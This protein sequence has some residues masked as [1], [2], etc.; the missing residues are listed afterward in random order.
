MFNYY[1]NQIHLPS[2]SILLSFLYLAAQDQES[3]KQSKGKNINFLVVQCITSYKPMIAIR[4]DMCDKTISL[5]FQG[6]QVTQ[7]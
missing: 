2:V 5:F 7:R 1:L 3:I 4:K 6:I